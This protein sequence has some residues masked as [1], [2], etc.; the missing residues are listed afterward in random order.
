MKNF[1]EFCLH[2]DPKQP[3]LAGI[4]LVLNGSNLEFTYT[5]AKAAVLDGVIFSVEWIDDLTQ[6]N[7][8]S[9]GVTEPS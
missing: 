6:T 5:R 8:S 1:L 9:A 4:S 7:W 2:T 3:S